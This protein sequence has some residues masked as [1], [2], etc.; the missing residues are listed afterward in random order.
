MQYQDNVLPWEVSTEKNNA[1][2]S[3]ILCKVFE[4]IVWCQ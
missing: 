3:G 4:K 1:A 2:K